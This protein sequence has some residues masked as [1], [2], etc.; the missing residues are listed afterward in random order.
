MFGSLLVP[1][2]GSAFAEQ[3]LPLALAIARRAGGR[4]DLVRAHILYAL[5]ERPYIRLPYDPALEAEWTQQEQLYLDATARWVTAGSRVPMSTALVYGLAADAILAH[6]QAGKADL[7][8]MTTHGRGPVS[9]FFLGS[10]ADELIRRAPVPLLLIR[11]REGATAPATEPVVEKVL[12]PLDGSALAEGVLEPALALARL[13]EARCTLLRV[14]ESGPV[15]THRIE[16]AVAEGEVYLEGLAGRLRA[17]ALRVEGQIVVAPHAAE[18]IARAAQTQGSDLIALATH[19]HG[20]AR[21]MLLGS[22]ADKVIRGTT[23]PVLV[24]RPPVG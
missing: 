13:L 14:V 22:V 24:Y 4:L 1:L 18:A 9:R 5:N 20:G 10:V 12:I 7:I 17:K 21:R 2:D 8:V 19:G 23:A 16:Q 11:P 3:A 15:P 6:A